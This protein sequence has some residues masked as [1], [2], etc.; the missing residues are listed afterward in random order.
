MA[1]GLNYY[2]LSV[3][4]WL[5][6]IVHNSLALDCIECMKGGLLRS[7][8]QT[9]VCLSLRRAVQ[10]RLNGSTSCLA[11]VSCVPVKHYILQ[12][13]SPCGGERGS[14]RPLPTYFAHLLSVPT[15][16]W[17]YVKETLQTC[18]IFVHFPSLQHANKSRISWRLLIGYLLLHNLTIMP[19]TDAKMCTVQMLVFLFGKPV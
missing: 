17:L 2:S 11:W 3:N 10:K 16:W 6:Y 14:M 9:S 12:P 7:M 4:T 5:H 8:I 1:V 18:K 13:P 15:N 19:S